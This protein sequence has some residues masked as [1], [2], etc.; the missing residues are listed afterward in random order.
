MP[1]LCYAPLSKSSPIHSPSFPCKM[2]LAWAV[3]Q[4]PWALTLRASVPIWEHKWEPQQVL[5]EEKSIPEP[6][7]CTYWP[8]LQIPPSTIAGILRLCG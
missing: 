5:E 1:L 8:F 6:W 7:S 3:F 4:D 2:E